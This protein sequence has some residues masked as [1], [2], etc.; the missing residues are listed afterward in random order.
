MKS[1]GW[2]AALF[3]LGTVMAGWSAETPPAVAVLDSPETGAMSAGLADFIEAGLEREGVPTFDRRYVQFWLAERNLSRSGLMDL[4][5]LQ[6]ARLPGMEFLVRGEAQAIGTNRFALTLK[7]FAP[8]MPL[9][10]QRFL[11]KAGIHKTGCRRW[12]A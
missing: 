2:I 9:S 4:K 11:K 3:L 1:K 5:T 7:L 12:S 8:A 6:Q 10:P